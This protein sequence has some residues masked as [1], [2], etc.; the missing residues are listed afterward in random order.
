MCCGSEFQ[1]GVREVVRIFSCY[2]RD[3]LYVASGNYIQAFRH[4]GHNSV[5]PN[6]DFAEIQQTLEAITL[7]LK[8]AN[9]P[10]RRKSLLCEMSR[11]LA[12]V[13]RISLQ[14]EWSNKPVRPQPV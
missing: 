2:R 8:T 13:E 11:L 14:F 3:L 6:D 7:E 10:E 4:N 9:D 12:G 1:F 5:M